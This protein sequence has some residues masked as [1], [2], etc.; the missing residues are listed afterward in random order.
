[1]AQQREVRS[2]CV[3]L[4]AS[5]TPDDRHRLFLEIRNALML[6]VIALGVI[7][8]VV[9]CFIAILRWAVG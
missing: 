7:A 1:M 9:I 3:T 4:P 8:Y 2:A 6:G 5:M